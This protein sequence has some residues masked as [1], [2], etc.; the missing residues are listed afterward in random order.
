MN[1]NSPCW[2]SLNLS[3]ELNYL[4]TTYLLWDSVSPSGLRPVRRLHEP[5]ATQASLAAEGKWQ[6]KCGGGFVI[7][8]RAGGPGNKPTEKVAGTKEQSRLPQREKT[9]RASRG[10]LNFSLVH[11]IERGCISWGAR[12]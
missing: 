7:I 12:N 3:G 11:C 4:S 8:G 9:Q 10:L 2:Q 6:D 1:V 5:L